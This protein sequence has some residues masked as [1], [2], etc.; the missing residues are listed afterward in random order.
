LELVVI[1]VGFAALTLTVAGVTFLAMRHAAGRRDEIIESIAPVE[2]ET[3]RCGICGGLG[4]N[5]EVRS[6]R[7]ANEVL[8]TC[9]RCGGAGVPPS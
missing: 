9:W 8:R 6:A 3:G 2:A 5:R 1:F 7:F 4:T